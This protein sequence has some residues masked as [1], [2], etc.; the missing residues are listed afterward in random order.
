VPRVGE[1]E[2]RGGTAGGL[3]DADVLTGRRGHA[4][5]TIADRP[6]GPDACGSS[7]GD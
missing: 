4:K 2:H 3:V 6:L 7:A 5:N 1:R